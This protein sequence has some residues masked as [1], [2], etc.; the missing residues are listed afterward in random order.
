VARGAT[1]PGRRITM[2][3]PNYCGGRRKVPTMSQVLSSIQYIYFR[4]TSG[5]NMGG[6][7]LASCP[8][9]HLTLLHPCI[10]GTFRRPTQS[11]GASPTVIRRPE[12]CAPF[13][14]TS[15]RPC[16]LANNLP[17]SDSLAHCLEQGSP[18]YGRRRNFVVDEKIL[19][20]T[21]E[22]LLIW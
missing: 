11:S 3:G 8:G 2:R 21:Y 10:A 16:T 17:V 1:F 4:K 14:P 22:N 18:N 9:R 13:A 5:S 15:L 7:K 12:N 20:C 6:A 19:Y